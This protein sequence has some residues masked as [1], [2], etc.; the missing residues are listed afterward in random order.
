MTDQPTDTERLRTQTVS[1]RRPRSA[2]RETVLE[3]A[4]ILSCAVALAN[5][6]GIDAVT[7][8]SLAEALGVSAMSL[9]A[10]VSDKD[11]ILDAVI[12]ARL[13]AIGLPDNALDW[14]PWMIELSRSLM[15]LL[16]NEPALLDRYCRRP[17]RVP[18]AL[19]RMDSALDRLL[20]A[21]FDDDEA[22]SALAATHTYT[23]G[24]AAVC[25]ARRGSVVRQANATGRFSGRQAK[26]PTDPRA[27]FAS[28]QVGDFPQL[29]RL[30]PDL[31]GF[32]TDT[33]FSV[34]LSALVDGLGD[35]RRGHRKA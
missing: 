30:R 31:H 14:R 33:Q 11:D 35:R 16:A 15:A 1:R 4:E 13:E 10:H 23:I 12:Q 17:V 29:A 34:G 22:V 28:L 25:A 7:M 24:F 27:V 3:R 21:G 32:T 19:A 2:R 26:E 6:K 9:Y 20:Q 5:A 8:R 18:A